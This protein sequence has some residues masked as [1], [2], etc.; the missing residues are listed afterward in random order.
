MRMTRGSEKLTNAVRG[1]RVNV[2]QVA[3]P[4]TLPGRLNEEVTN[5]ELL[6]RLVVF[7]I[8]MENGEGIIGKAPDY[9]M[10]KW[11]LANADLSDECILGGLDSMNQ[12]KYNVWKERWGWSDAAR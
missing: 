5:M 6:N 3:L 7:A 4:V 8:F 9:I 2:I 11:R 10:E 1:A 12:A